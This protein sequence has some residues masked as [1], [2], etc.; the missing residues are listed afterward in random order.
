[1]YLC[2]CWI[3][4][5]PAVLISFQHGSELLVPDDSHPSIIDIL[6]CVHIQLNLINA[7]RDFIPVRSYREER[8]KKAVL[9]GGKNKKPISK[10]RG[11]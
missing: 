1:L 4:Y 9:S 3:L 2:I 11:D 8:R 5:F 6:A 7:W 10:C